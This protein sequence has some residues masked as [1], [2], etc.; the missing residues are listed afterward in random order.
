MSTTEA[1]QD[2]AEEVDVVDVGDV[3]VDPV[4]SAKTLGANRAIV[5]QEGMI[6]II[7]SVDKKSSCEKVSWFLF[8]QRAS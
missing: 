3:V 6:V 5:A 2:A 7:A 4:R 8:Q 1:V